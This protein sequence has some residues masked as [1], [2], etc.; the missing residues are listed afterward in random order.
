MEIQSAERYYGQDELL[1]FVG[2]ADDAHR[3]AAAVKKLEERI[4]SL[5]IELNRMT[6]KLGAFRTVHVYL[7]EIDALPLV[8]GQETS[9]QPDLDRANIGLFVFRNRVGKV[10]WQ[11]LNR[12]RDREEDA[13]TVLAAFPRIP[14]DPQLLGRDPAPMLWADLVTKRDSLTADWAAKKSK[15]VTPLQYESI[16]DLVEKTFSTLERLLQR[17]FAVGGSDEASEASALQVRS[18]EP[19]ATEGLSPYLRTLVAGRKYLPLRGL[20]IETS[21]AMGESKPIELEQIYVGLDTTTQEKI[22]GTEAK[23]RDARALA[24]RE[25][26]RP[27]SALKA[28]ADNRRAVILGSPG[29]GKSTF[30]SHIC[31]CLAL[32]RLEPEQG[33][34]G[35]LQ[36]WPETKDS[37]IPVPVILRDFARTLPARGRNP[38]PR[39]LWEFIVARLNDQSVEF[40]ADSLRACLEGGKAILLLDGLDEVPTVS[41]RRQVRDAVAVFSDRYHDCRVLVTC[42]TLSYQDPK[43]QLED[44]PSFELAPFDSEKIDRF[45]EAWYGELERLSVISSGDAG[46][47]AGR[48]KEAVRRP[49]IQRLAP[50]PLLLTAMALVHTHKGRLPDARAVLYEDTVDLLLWRWEELKIRDE[51]EAPGMRKLLREVGREDVDLKRA[52]WR[53]AFEAHGSTGKAGVGELADIDENELKGTLARLHPEESGVW[54]IKVIDVMK[55]RAGL[56]LE[57]APGLYTFPHRTF[58]EYL[59]G[60]HLAAQGDFTKLAARLAA[61]VPMWREVIILAVGKIVYLQGETDKPLFLVSQLCPRV[62]R[63]SPTAWQKSWLAGE[64]LIEIGIHRVRESDLGNEL[65]ERVRERLSQLLDAGALTVVQRAAAGVVLGRLGDSRPGVSIV[66]NEEGRTLPDIEWVDVEPGQFRMGCTDEEAEHSDEKPAF[67]CNLV[68]RPFRISKYP[69]TVAQFQ[70]FIDADGYG[71]RSYWTAAGWEWRTKQV[72]LGPMDYGEVYQTPNHPCVGVRWYEARACCGWLSEK[73]GYAVSLPTEAQWE[74]AAR[75]S[76]WRVYPWGNEEDRAERCNLDETGIGH[77]SAVGMFPKG[78]A[79]CGAHDMAGN[80]WEWCS[81]KWRG[82]YADYEQSVDDDPEGEDPRVLRG[83]SFVSY[84]DF[85]RCAARFW[86]DPLERDGAVGFRVVAPPFIL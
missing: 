13:V 21:D 41:Q 60:A 63:E 3:E 49:D 40:A 34:L 72:N 47:L 66:R 2:H 20:D 25:W 75:H 73:L 58:Q 37:P 35:R 68:R 82:D 15:S 33:W 84:R 39:H 67:D 29:S 16:D 30:L 38:N 48:L 19:S 1:I 46:E 81:T 12:F 65:L 9:I 74:R 36:G 32:H 52:L 59:A 80:V 78:A 51:P 24:E 54:A 77:T 23:E 22:E 11:E 14:P 8:G 50:N 85:V 55:M 42:R 26:P 18:G 43:W 6:K 70:C 27:L 69:I 83:G 79:Q 56:L 61:D 76:D 5:L 86:I 62:G 7:W 4:Q 17:H 64:L 53:L 31:L 45:V 28:V 10:T 71:E 57:R 44:I